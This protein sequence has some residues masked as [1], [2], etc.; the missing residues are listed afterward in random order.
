MVLRRI[1]WA[2][3]REGGAA[4]PLTVTFTPDQLEKMQD[5]YIKLH[6]KEMRREIRNL[7]RYGANYKLILTKFSDY[8]EMRV[9]LG[10]LP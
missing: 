9:I 6:D 2:L 10:E 1:Q 5:D 7:N 8:L 4:T 3:I